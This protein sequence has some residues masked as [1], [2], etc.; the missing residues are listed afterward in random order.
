MGALF[1]YVCMHGYESVLRV[2]MC[3]CVYLVCVCCSCNVTMFVQLDMTGSCFV[4]LNIE[5]L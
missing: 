5:H 4:L 2:F 1:V 3:V